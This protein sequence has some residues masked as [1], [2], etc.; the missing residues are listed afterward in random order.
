MKNKIK[1]ALLLLLSLSF[2]GACNNQDTSSNPEV[3]KESTVSESENE[4]TDKREKITENK[5]SKQV[6]KD[7]EKEE[8]DNK[9]LKTSEEKQD[10]ENDENQLDQASI[11][12]DKLFEEIKNENDKVIKVHMQTN[13]EDTYPDRTK[14]ASFIADP[15]YDENQNIIKGDTKKELSNGYLQEIKFVENDDSRAMILERQPGEEETSVSDV[16]IESYD[17]KPD[18]HRLVQAIMDMKDDLEVSEEADSYKLNLKDKA[19]D[20]IKYVQEEYIINVSDLEQ[21]QIEKSVEVEI[22]KETKLLKKF[23]LGLKPKV[24]ELEDNKLTA[25]TILSDHELGN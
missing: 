14:K 5:E 6:S 1:L 23:A 18:Y 16:K 21:N 24:K 8:V 11:D 9:D 10:E 20:V 13:I 3:E 15:V 12:I 19:M 2:L 7:K 25:E 22:D 4:V 17:I